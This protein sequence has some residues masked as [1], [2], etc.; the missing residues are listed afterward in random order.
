MTLSHGAVVLDVHG[1]NLCV[2]DCL[3]ETG[4]DEDI[5]TL[6]FYSNGELAYRWDYDGAILLRGHED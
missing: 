5:R 4:E 3:N 1:Q 6:I 2:S